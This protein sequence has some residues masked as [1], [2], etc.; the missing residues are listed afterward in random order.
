MF[1]SVIFQAFCVGLLSAASLPLGTITSVFWKP[2]DKA[3]AFLMAFGGGA[4]LAALTI[5]LV[6]DA[7]DQGQFSS[8]AIGCVLGSLLFIGLNQIINNHG[9]FLRK[10]STIIYY[11]QRQEQRRFK[12]ILSSMGRLPIFKNLPTEEQKRIVECIDVREYPKGATLFHSGDPGD[13]IYIIA[14]GEIDLCNPG[15]H[16]KV[17]KRIGKKDAFGWLS[18]LTGAPHRMVAITQSKVR[19]WV[20]SRKEFNHCRASR[21]KIKTCASAYSSTNT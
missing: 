7:L 2:G 17:S 8:L 18:F 4:L 13:R 15:D 1:E 6:G 9:G 11:F 21:R 10:S 3:I 12:R 19:L 14:E 16:M 20:L 5:D